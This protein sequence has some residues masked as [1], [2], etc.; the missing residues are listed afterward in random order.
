MDIRELDGRALDDVDRVVDRVPAD[1]LDAP[2]PCAEWDLRALLTHMAGNNHGFADAA[3]GRPVDPAVWDGADLGDDV[4][5]EYRRSA[6]RVREAF[7]APG[8]LDGTLHVH[9]FGAFPAAAAIGM[10]FVDYLAHGWDVA[11]AIGIE[12]RL[13]PELCDAVL[14]I[15]RRWPPDSPAV[16]GEGAPFRARL[17]VS[18]NA[19]TADRMLAFLGRS[20]EWPGT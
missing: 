9:G 4:V 16:W 12:H 13:D 19:S 11:K 6:R 1:R 8:V 2:T 15:G 17:P 20:P 14:R 7:A 5:E 18:E 10:H 3:A